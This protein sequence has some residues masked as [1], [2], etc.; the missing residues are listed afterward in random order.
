MTV[1]VVDRIGAWVVG[2]MIFGF[3]LAVVWS[4]LND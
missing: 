1:E 3:I 2:L 4:A